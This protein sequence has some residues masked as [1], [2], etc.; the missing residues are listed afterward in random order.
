MYS[1]YLALREKIPI[2]MPSVKPS[3][4][5]KEEHQIQREA[6]DTEVLQLIF[7]LQ[8]SG[9]ITY[10]VGGSV[11]DLLLQ[12]PPKDFDVVTEAKPGKIKQIFRSQCFLIGR[13]FRLAHV[14]LKGRV[15]EVSTFR[16]GDNDKC[17]LI[18]QDNT[19]GSP[20]ED[21]LRR[22]FTI[23]ALFYDP[24]KEIIVDFIGGWKDIERK[25]LTLIGDPVA[26][27]TQDPVR[28]IRLLRFLARFPFFIEENTKN[29]LLSCRREILKSCSPR[30][31]EELLRMLESPYAL[32]FLSLLFKWDFLSLLLPE[33]NAFIRS[34]HNHTT[35]CYLQSAR[36]YALQEKCTLERPVI[37]SCLLFPILQSKIEKRET[38]SEQKI[39]MEKVEKEILRIIQL[40]L[41]N[42]LLPF[43]QK[44]CASV[45]AILKMQ[46]QIPLIKKR[47]HSSSSLQGILIRQAQQFFS[48]RTLIDLT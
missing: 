21:A 38:S 12:L 18:L 14:H 32:S 48:I 43:P 29:A 31:I 30:V 22:D 25:R 37:L 3:I 9:F 47:R 23:N 17:E 13:R 19:W 1:S 46:Y 11:R 20:R 8:R 39:S 10:L 26:R 41:C 40:V 6:I 4:Y 33:L 5:S 16:K 35:F 27:L 34:D 44:I 36:K 7:R 42:K 28:M 45:E 15:I 2:D 24:S